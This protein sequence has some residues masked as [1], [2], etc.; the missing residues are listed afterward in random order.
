[1]V[2][3]SE[4]MYKKNNNNNCHPLNKVNFDCFKLYW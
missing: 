2:S 4:K 3:I 1:M